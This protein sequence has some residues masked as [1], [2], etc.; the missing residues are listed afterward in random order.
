[1]KNPNADWGM[2]GRFKQKPTRNV[3]NKPVAFTDVRHPTTK[4]VVD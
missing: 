3:S 2:D 1:V 4:K